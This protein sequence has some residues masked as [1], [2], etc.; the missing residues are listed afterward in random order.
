MKNE[1]A[2]LNDQVHK[3]KVKEINTVFLCFNPTHTKTDKCADIPVDIENPDEGVL[4]N[5]GDQSFVDVLYD[6]VKEFGIDMFGQ[7]ITGVS[8]LQTREGFDICLCG[9]LQLSMAQPLGHVLIGHAHQLT[10][11][12]KVTIVGLQKQEQISVINSRGQA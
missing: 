1:T 8:S 10:E 7:C 2:A 5:I 3:G 12:R 9:C 6:P 11:R 4:F